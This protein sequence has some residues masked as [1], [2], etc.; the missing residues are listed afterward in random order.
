MTDLNSNEPLWVGMDVDR[1][2]ARYAAEDRRLAEAEPP[3]PPKPRRS[4]RRGGLRAAIPALVTGGA[5]QSP[6]A[7]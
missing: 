4:P 3:S 2:L 6:L 7:A 5:P 1:E